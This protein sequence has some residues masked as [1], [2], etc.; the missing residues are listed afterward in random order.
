MKDYAG[1]REICPSLRF[2]RDASVMTMSNHL[3]R[4]LLVLLNNRGD[5]RPLWADR[6]LVRTGSIDP[7]SHQR[8]TLRWKLWQHMCAIA[9]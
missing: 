6:E 3:L 9:A 8:E 2:A 1:S 7:F 4:L 5:Y